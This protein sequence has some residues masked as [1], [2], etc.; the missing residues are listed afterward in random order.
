MLIARPPPP[1]ET[2]FT[3]S[4]SY[5]LP[6]PGW[7]WGDA[8]HQTQAWSHHP[9]T[10]LPRPF[11]PTSETPVVFAG[12]PQF[13]G[14]QLQAGSPNN[15]LSAPQPSPE[16]WNSFLAATNSHTPP[17]S[18]PPPLALHLPCGLP[19]PPPL[20]QGTLPAAASAL[21][22]QLPTKPAEGPKVGQELA[23]TRHT[24]TDTRGRYR[25]TPSTLTGWRLGRHLPHRLGRPRTPM[26]S[27]S[28]TSTVPGAH[29][30]SPRAAP[31][32]PH[33]GSFL[34]LF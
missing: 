16:S 21:L 6:R 28:D 10:L 5:Q 29:T 12:L 30:A 23:T 2:G 26:P 7:G 22:P 31:T 11:S 8:A 27:R 32:H 3:P 19:D 4:P 20:A 1:R 13:P 9:I 14:R 24:H 18:A 17:S 15:P 25:K 33:P 34:G